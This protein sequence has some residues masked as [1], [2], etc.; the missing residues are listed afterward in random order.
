MELRQELLQVRSLILS[1]RMEQSLAVLQMSEAELMECAAAEC[2]K[3]PLLDMEHRQ[4]PYSYKYHSNRT[5]RDDQA[6]DYLQ[7]IAKTACSMGEYLIEQVQE[8][9][10]SHEIAQICCVFANSLDE[11]GYLDPL[12][13]SLLQSSGIAATKIH[14]AYTAFLTLEPVGIGALCLEHC[15]WLQLT[16]AQKIRY[17]RCMP[18]LHLLCSGG[19]KRFCDKTKLSA[20][21]LQG[22][23]TVLATLNPKPGAGLGQPQ[24]VSYT[25]PDLAIAA[26][27]VGFSAHLFE[28]KAWK[29]SVNTAYRSNLQGEIDE[30]TSQY[31]LKKQ[32]QG[33]YLIDAIQRREKP[34]ST[35]G[36]P[37]HTDNRTFFNTAP[38][39]YGLTLWPTLPYILVYTHLP[40]AVA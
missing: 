30:A 12:V 15:L 3:N 27:E 32:T 23:L 19:H 7:N 39:R 20:K 10:L 14:E 40:S 22:L 26:D 18:Y 28:E 17:A 36:Q 6:L 29:L 2:E 25:I 33:Q 1:Q 37:L 31:L 11:R 38:L 13:F 9:P 21:E 16:T 8:L 24:A 34:C 4:T 35:S 5:Y